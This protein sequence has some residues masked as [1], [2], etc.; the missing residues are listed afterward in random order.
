MIVL[1]FVSRVGLLF[2]RDSRAKNAQ[3]MPAVGAP[4]NQPDAPPEQP[5]IAEAAEFGPSKILE[6]GVK[7]QEATLRRQSVPMKVSMA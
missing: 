2:M 4:R 3:A 7:F 5:A 6:F 1:V